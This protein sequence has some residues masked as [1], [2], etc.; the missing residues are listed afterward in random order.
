[1]ATLNHRPLPAILAALK[2]HQRRLRSLI[3]RAN[4]MD[5]NLA[6]QIEDVCH[7][8]ALLEIEYTEAA[9]ARGPED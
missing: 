3:A 9:K 4:M 5:P 7:T 2:H 6:R 8:L 1:M